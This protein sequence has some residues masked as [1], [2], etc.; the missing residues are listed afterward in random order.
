MLGA[1]QEA[2]YKSGSVRLDPGDMLLAYSDGLTECRN[3]QD[4]EFEI[5]TFIGSSK[6]DHVARPQIRFFSPRLRRFSTSPTRVRRTMTCH[7]WLFVAAT[8]EPHGADF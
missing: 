6:V 1:L 8:V 3:P 5:G 4:E 2:T 7:S